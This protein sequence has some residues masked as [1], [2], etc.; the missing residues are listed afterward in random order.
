MLIHLSAIPGLCTAVEG[1]Y[2]ST[3]SY[4]LREPTGSYEIFRPNVWNHFC[5]GYRKNDS[6][7]RIT[8]ARSPST[9]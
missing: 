8:K 3:S 9:L 4:L 7:I 2:L 6:Y 1:L 5:L